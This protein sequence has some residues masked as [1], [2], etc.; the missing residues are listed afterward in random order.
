MAVHVAKQAG[1]RARRP[2]VSADVPILP[3]KITAP[4]VP[5]WALPRPLM[6][7]SNPSRNLATFFQA[8]A[9]P[10]QVAPVGLSVNRNVINK[11]GHLHTRPA[12]GWRSGKGDKGGTG[13]GNLHPADDL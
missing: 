10:G 7:D 5:D 9:E 3:S 13:Q 11:D 1:A 8:R 12:E 6:L 2:T 4:N